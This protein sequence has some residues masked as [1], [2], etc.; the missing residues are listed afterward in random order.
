MRISYKT[1][2]DF[3]RNYNGR[4]TE[5]SVGEFHSYPLQVAVLEDQKLILAVGGFDG[6]T[7]LSSAE[8]FD[9]RIG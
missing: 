9:N 7:G 2:T 6:N 3:H 4:L 8:A 1:G 5:G